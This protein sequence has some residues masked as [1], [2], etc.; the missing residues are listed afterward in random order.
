MTEQYIKCFKP[1]AI[2]GPKLNILIV[3]YGALGKRKGRHMKLQAQM[4]FLL[5]LSSKNRSDI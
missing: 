5:I 2:H 4:S 1:L 3:G